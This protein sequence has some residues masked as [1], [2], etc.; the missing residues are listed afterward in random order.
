[1]SRT[2]C[3]DFVDVDFLLCGQGTPLILDSSCAR[4]SILLGPKLDCS[5]SMSTPYHYTPRVPAPPHP[6]PFSTSSHA[7]V[8]PK[9]SRAPIQN[10]YEKFTQPEFDA[11]IGGI[12]GALRRALGEDEQ[13]QLE[14]PKRLDAH[15][16]T[17]PRYSQLELGDEADEV[18]DDSFAEIKARRAGKGKA[19]DPRDGPG[20]GNGNRVQPIEIVSSDEED[21]DEVQELAVNLEG[22]LE[23]EEEEE[24]ERNNDD[25]SDEED[26]FTDEKQSWDAGESSSYA[27]SPPVKIGPPRK[28]KPK[29]VEEE[30]EKEDEYEMEYEE[31]YD[32]E[33][34]EEYYDEEDDEETQ[35]VTGGSPEVI[36]LVSDEEEEEPQHETKAQELAKEEDGDGDGELDEEYDEYEEEDQN[37]VR[38]LNQPGRS[39]ET[40]V[41]PRAVDGGQYGLQEEEEYDEYEEYD[42][43][44][45]EVGEYGEGD[46]EDG[47]LEEN[48]GVEDMQP[49]QDDTCKSLS[50]F[51]H[52]RRSYLSFSLSSSSWFARFLLTGATRHP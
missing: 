49:L 46:E 44:D 32:E 43:D 36:E 10:P 13:L 52:L 14:G 2:L 45:Y 11:W 47:V 31:E 27:L 21:E 18:A 30:D 15:G 29:Q 34:G 8:K 33:D 38:D 3:L 4:P 35:F 12:T 17:L 5:A 16:G 19:R 28:T 23:D 9:T 39:F 24:V 25:D 41:K 26:N 20:F 48:K 22:G 7:L 1:M 6:T 37:N 51:F 40:L 50:P 42:G